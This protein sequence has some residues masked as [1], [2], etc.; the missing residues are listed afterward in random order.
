MQI[1]LRDHEMLHAW[2]ASCT[3]RQ[4]AV[5]AYSQLKTL[6]MRTRHGDL[7]LPNENMGRHTTASEQAPL[8]AM[9]NSAGREQ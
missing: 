3:A 4:T 6:L 2:L 8:W 7:L 5:L 1:K 9:L